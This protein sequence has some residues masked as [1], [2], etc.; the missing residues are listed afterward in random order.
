MQVGYTS[1]TLFSGETRREL[2][3]FISFNSIPPKETIVHSL[4]QNVENKKVNKSA[5]YIENGMTNT[6]TFLHFVT[7]NKTK[8][9]SWE[10]Y[11][12]M[13]IY[14]ANMAYD[15]AE[16]WETI[17]LIPA[18]MFF[19]LL[20]VWIGSLV[21]HTVSSAY[22]LSLDSLCFR[23]VF[24]KFWY[25]RLPGLILIYGYQIR[26]EVWSL[27]K[28]RVFEKKRFARKSGGSERSITTRQHLLF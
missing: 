24:T 26:Y 23:L 9:Y 1:W 15:T 22:L 10:V 14:G 18:L 25:I 7:T 28:S 27:G 11:L 12:F 4:N 21:Y 13:V 17:P 20:C 16:R 2:Y 5:N 19:G 8:I 3:L 6:W